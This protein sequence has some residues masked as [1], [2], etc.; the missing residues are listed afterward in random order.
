MQKQARVV[1]RALTQ[2][3]Y[4]SGLAGHL[5]RFAGQQQGDMQSTVYGERD[6]PE[7]VEHCH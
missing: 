1:D 6:H 2:A 5:R 3:V 7:L 4:R